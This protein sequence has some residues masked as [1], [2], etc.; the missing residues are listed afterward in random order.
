MSNGES[1]SRTSTMA[2][3]LVRQAVPPESGPHGKSQM[4]WCASVITALLSWSERWR[5]EKPHWSLWASQC[6][7]GN[8]QERAGPRLQVEAEKWLEAGL[9][10][11]P[12]KHRGAHGDSHI[13]IISQY[14]K[15]L[16]KSI[17]EGDVNVIK[18]IHE[19][20]TLKSIIVYN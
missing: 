17:M 11:P 15:S 7:A 19:N 6:G 18:Y 5:R 13:L 14:F 16:L 3:Q 20:V 2:Q 9:L 10:W 8:V 12:H 1:P 4:R